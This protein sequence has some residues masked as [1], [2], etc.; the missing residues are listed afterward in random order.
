MY[1]N[2]VRARTLDLQHSC[3][4]HEGYASPTELVKWRVHSEGRN[5]DNCTEC[6]S[7]SPVVL[8]PSP[9][10]LCADVGVCFEHR[11]VMACCLL[12]GMHGHSHWLPVEAAPIPRRKSAIRPK[13][14]VFTS[15]D[16]TPLP[17]ISMSFRA[18][19]PSWSFFLVSLSFHHL[20]IQK[21][22]FVYIIC[23]ST[24]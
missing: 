14:R 9:L 6:F 8:F 15:I 20:R 21:H 4:L 13:R 7:Q 18:Q 16:P 23:K 3:T 24:S 2:L 1:N 5:E 12:Q 19:Q 22:S 17:F 11:G 10:H